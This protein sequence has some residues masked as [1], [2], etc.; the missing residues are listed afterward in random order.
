MK[1]TKL[2]ETIKVGFTTYKIIPM[3]GIRN[4]LDRLGE[5]D[6]RQREIR[7][8]NMGYPMEAA[9][10][11]LHEVLHAIKYTSHIDMGDFAREEYLVAAISKAL[12]TVIVDNPGLLNWM[13]ETI[14]SD[15]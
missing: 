3:D 13:H 4:R 2:P 11:L 10:T 7:V 9:E 15:T 14:R 6:H 1:E 12:M 8:E 5:F